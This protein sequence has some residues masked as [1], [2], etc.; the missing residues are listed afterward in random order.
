MKCQ[1]PGCRNKVSKVTKKSGIFTGVY[2]EDV[3]LYTCGNHQP[4]DVANALEAV[5]ERKA[6][7]SQ[8]INPYVDVQFV[9]RLA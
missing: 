6:A 5:G 1:I 3:T 4:K 8:M 2:L 9:P 7:D